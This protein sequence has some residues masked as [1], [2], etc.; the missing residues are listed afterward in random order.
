MM[1]GVQ[2]YSRAQA[3][4]VGQRRVAASRQCRAAG[5]NARSRQ[6]ERHVHLRNFTPLGSESAD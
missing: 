6:Y 5:M 3:Q 4:S 1:R 2:S